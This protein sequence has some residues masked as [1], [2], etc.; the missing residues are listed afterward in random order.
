MTP[1]LC[2][3]T[4]DSGATA[5]SKAEEV[6]AAWADVCTNGIPSVASMCG[7]AMTAIPYDA[8]PSDFDIYDICWTM[9]SAYVPEYPSIVS[10]EIC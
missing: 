8:L 3:E 7:T 5:T 1:I 6:C 10:D 4:D 2:G 9:S